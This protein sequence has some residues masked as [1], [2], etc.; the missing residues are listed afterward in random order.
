MNALIAVG[1]SAAY[2]Y[3]A[4]VT[5]LPGYFPFESVCFDS[6]TIIIT[7]IQANVRKRH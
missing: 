3:S 6:S 2:F 4:I 1:T 5:I 7:L